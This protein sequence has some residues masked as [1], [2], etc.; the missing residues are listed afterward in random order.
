M[1]V[2]G[3]LRHGNSNLAACRDDDAPTVTALLRSRTRVRVFAI[4]RGE[5]REK[6][7]LVN[8]RRRSTRKRRETWW[9]WWHTE[10]L[11]CAA[12][13]RFAQKC[14]WLS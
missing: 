9:W 13:G 7:F 3:E 10:L 6:R 14:A 2:S 1:H 11:R 5:A 12:L 8:D 4:V